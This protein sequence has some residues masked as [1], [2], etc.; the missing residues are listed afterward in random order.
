[1]KKGTG[2]RAA[3]SGPLANHAKDWGDIGLETFVLSVDPRLQDSAL[4]DRCEVS[5]HR[6]AE[7]QSDW[8]N[9]NGEKWRPR[10]YGRPVVD[11][12]SAAQACGVTLRWSI[13]C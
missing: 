6:W 4:A 5:L 8:K 3:R 2:S 7:E 13:S 1:M 11:E 12:L 9:F 10:N